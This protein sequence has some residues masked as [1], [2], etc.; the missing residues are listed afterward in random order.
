MCLLD[1]LL[2]AAANKQNNSLRELGCNC[3]AEFA[4]WTLKYQMKDSKEAPQNIKS[5]IRRI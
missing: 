4:K 5:L 1:S 3:V 2:D